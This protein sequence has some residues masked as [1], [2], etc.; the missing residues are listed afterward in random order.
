MLELPR[1]SSD[2]RS[3]TQLEQLIV[4]GNSVRN[5]SKANDNVDQPL[6]ALR[7]KAYFPR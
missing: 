7:K 5:V 1:T 6:V 3:A 2:R 4:R